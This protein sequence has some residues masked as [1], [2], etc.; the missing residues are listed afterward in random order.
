MLFFPMPSIALHVGGSA[1]D[2]RI[3]ICVL[4][5]PTPNLFIS[6]TISGSMGLQAG[7]AAASRRDFPKGASTKGARSFLCC[8]SVVGLGAFAP[9]PFVPASPPFFLRSWLVFLSVPCFC[10]CCEV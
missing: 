3:L 5:A 7:N 2:A 10:F 1:F 6:Y 4:A 8:G 9:P